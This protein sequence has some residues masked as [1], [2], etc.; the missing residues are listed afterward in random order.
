MA[1][2]NT[3]IIRCAVCLLPESLCTCR[4]SQ[5][6]DTSP[7]SFPLDQK[8][9]KFGYR[10]HARPVGQQPVWRDESGRLVDQDDVLSEILHRERSTERG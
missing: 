3:D 9:R 1:K 10:L 4:P 8:I 7:R 5:N 2:R 6:T